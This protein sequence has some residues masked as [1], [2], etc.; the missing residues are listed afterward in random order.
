M[1]SFENFWTTLSSMNGLFTIVLSDIVS[2]MSVASA[3]VY[4]LLA[5]NVALLLIISFTILR[6]VRSVFPTC[7][8]RLVGAGLAYSLPLPL[9]NK[10][11]SYYAA[12]EHSLTAIDD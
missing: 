12:C 5:V 11:H 6:N 8:H 2:L 10:L 7:Q 9:C 4:S 1:R 3:I